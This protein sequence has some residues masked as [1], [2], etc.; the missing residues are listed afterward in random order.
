MGWVDKTWA[1]EI[2]EVLNTPEY[3]TALI[4]ILDPAKT[5][6]TWDIETNTEITVGNPVVASGIHARINWPLRSVADPG[7]IDFD[8]TTVRSGRCSIDYNEYSGPLRNGMQ[9]LVTY[10]G[11]NPD[12]LRYRFWV[13]EAQNSSEMSSRVFKITVDGEAVTGNGTV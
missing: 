10:G 1:D 3:H 7:S 5:T 2:A 6:T 4:T 11:R 12:L 9:V 8:P 13:A